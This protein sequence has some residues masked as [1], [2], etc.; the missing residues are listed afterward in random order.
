VGGVAGRNSGP[1]EIAADFPEDSVQDGARIEGW[2]AAGRGRG[3]IGEE[4]L[5]KAPLLVGEV[6]KIIR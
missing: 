6:Q 5:D 4:G 3:V 2:A 1:G